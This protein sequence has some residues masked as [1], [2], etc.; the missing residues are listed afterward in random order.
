MGY[1]KEN[2]VDIENRSK[3]LAIGFVKT[4]GVLSSLTRLSNAV[5][6]P[7]ANSNLFNLLQ[8]KTISGLG[9][10][11]KVSSGLQYMGEMLASP[12]NRARLFD[13]MKSVAPSAKATAIG[14]GIGAL[15]P[16]MTKLR[17]DMHAG[18]INRNNIKQYFKDNIRT[19][20]K[21]SLI[22]GAVGGGLG[23]GLSYA[24]RALGNYN[25]N[26]LQKLK[27]IKNDGHMFRDI[28]EYLVNQRKEKL[29]SAV[30]KGVLGD[31]YLTVPELR[32]YN[33]LRIPNPP[34]P[35]IYMARKERGKRFLDDI[36]NFN[37]TL[38][39]KVKE[40]VNFIN[41]SLSGHDSLKLNNP[42]LYNI[43][44]DLQ[45][46]DSNPWYYVSKKLKGGY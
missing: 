45:S 46:G 41:S 24:D 8:N 18:K 22:G 10:K 19:Y 26:L 14:A 34:D 36:D 13:A 23:A 11:L 6:S 42:S 43:W 37:T 30:T 3:T 4:A 20:G 21:N 16:A 5:A 35:D 40:R 9:D 39:D 25:S 31:G 7:I 2:N 17:G 44:G 38:R 12:E 32:F 28:P 15:F 29:L 33:S 1:N 27:G